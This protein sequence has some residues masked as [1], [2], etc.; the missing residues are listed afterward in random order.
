MNS[1]I[2]R[3]VGWFLR[4]KRCSLLWG[5]SRKSQVCM[6]VNLN[7]RISS[8]RNDRASKWRDTVISLLFRHF[9]RT[10]TGKRR[11]HDHFLHRIPIFR[12][13]SFRMRILLNSDHSWLERTPN[14]ERKRTWRNL[15]RPR[16]ESAIMASMMLIFNSHYSPQLKKMIQNTRK[17][18]SLLNLKPCSFILQISHKNSLFGPYLKQVNQSIKFT[19]IHLIS[20]DI[21][22]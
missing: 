5:S 4:I 12:R 16:S 8:L 20:I 7:S 6:R 15:M 1:R 11:N 14:R 21:I 9:R 18:S 13:C 19:F 3:H 22:N 10:C 2:R 17:V